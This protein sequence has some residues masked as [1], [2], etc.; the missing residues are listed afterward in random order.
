[1][2]TGPL[3][4]RFVWHELMTSDPAA[5]MAFYQKLTGWKKEPYADVPDYTMFVGPR[6]PVG[7]CMALPAEAAGMGVPPNWLSYIG[8][9]DTDAT[10]REAET[11]GGKVIKGPISIPVGRFAIIS[12]PQGVVFA[13]YTPNLM[14]DSDPKAQVGEF[15]WHELATTDIN[16]AWDFYSKLFGWEKTRA[17]DMG[18]MGVYQI[19]GLPGLELGG[20]YKV[21]PNFPAPPHWLPYIRIADVKKG[22]AQATKLGGKIV[23][24]PMEVPGGDLIAMG[25]DPQGAAFA[26]HSSAAMPAAKAARPAPKKKAAAKKP[27]K[28]AAKKAAPKKKMVT[29]AK[30][31]AAPKKKAAKK[32]GR[33]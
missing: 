32:K 7:G 19:Y 8:T 16:A 15:S 22:A 1:M 29:K 33:R 30:K 21:P 27:A 6:G 2:A 31:K 13:I 17:M 12:D 23:N 3:R 20:I 18:D 9:S 14:D 10:A 25:A 28:A 4:G 5:G 26:I 11:L 24:G